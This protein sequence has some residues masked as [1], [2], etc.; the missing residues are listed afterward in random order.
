M[1]KIVIIEDEKPAIEKLVNMLRETHPETEVVG[2]AM[3]VKQAV[4]WFSENPMPDIILMDIA[5]TDGTSFDIF[6]KVNITCPVIFITAYDEYWQEAFEHNGI[7]YLLKPVKMEKLVAALD[8]YT[9]LKG[10]FKD[11]I[12]KLMH[13][14]PDNPGA[15]KKRFLVKRGN[16]LFSIKTEDI[17][18]F[19]AA[20]KMVCMVD[21]KG[22]RF[23]LDQSLNELEKQ[24]DPSDFNRVNRKFIIQKKMILRAKAYSKSKLLLDVDPPMTEDIIVSQEYVGRFKDWFGS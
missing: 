13:Y 18:Y 4:D 3:S 19:Y 15:F 24:L 22:Q 14:A 1:K 17:A 9:Q 12:E 6:E 21:S 8:W 2:I 23:V 16:D 20:D 7:D 10:H 5:L 11:K